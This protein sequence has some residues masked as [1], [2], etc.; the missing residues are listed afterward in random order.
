MNQVLKKYTES[1][2]VNRNIIV[3]V[4]KTFGLYKTILMSYG[5]YLNFDVNITKVLIISAIAL[6]FSVF[7][8]FIKY[9]K[10]ISLVQLI[11]SVISFGQAALLFMLAIGGVVMSEE[12]SFSLFLIFLLLSASQIFSGIVLLNNKKHLYIV[13]VIFFIL[14]L[15]FS[16]YSYIIRVPNIIEIVK[17]SVKGIF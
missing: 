17:D 9:E 13:I 16:L 14:Q 8:S 4:L 1:I 7:I 10:V 11:F 5:I 12:G 2:K 15:L 6:P 3:K